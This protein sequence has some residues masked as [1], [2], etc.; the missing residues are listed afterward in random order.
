MCEDLQRGARVKELCPKTCGVCGTTAAPKTAAPTA[1]A[2]DL[3]TAIVTQ[4]PSWSKALNVT[5]ES[6]G[7][8][9]SYHV[10]FSNCEETN[11][12]YHCICGECSDSV[13]EFIATT[14][15]Q[16]WCDDQCTSRCK[17]SPTTRGGSGKGEQED[18]RLVGRAIS[19]SGVVI[20]PTSVPLDKVTKVPGTLTCVDDDA[21]MKE[22][23][24]GKAADCTGAAD[25]CED[26]QRGARVK[27]L[28]P[29]TCG[30]CTIAPSAPLLSCA[31]GSSAVAGSCQPCPPG[32]FTMIPGASCSRCAPGTF[33]SSEGQASCQLCP[34]GSFSSTFGATSC[35]KCQKGFT[36]TRGQLSCVP[37]PVG[38]S[39]DGSSLP[40]N[41]DET[42]P[43]ARITGEQMLL[44]FLPSL[45]DEDDEVTA[46]PTKITGEQMLL[47]FLP[48]LATD[49]PKNSPAEKPVDEP[50][51]MCCM[52]MT[53]ECLACKKGVSVE[54][55]C[56]SSANKEYCGKPSACM[57]DEDC[58]AGKECY[59]GGSDHAACVTKGNIGIARPTHAPVPMVFL[60]LW[61]PCSLSQFNAVKEPLKG[62]L[63]ARA[64]ISPSRLHFG[65]PKSA[66]ATLPAEENSTSGLEQLQVSTGIEVPVEIEDGPGESA[67]QAADLLK[68]ANLT[69]LVKLVG[70]GAFF[71]SL[72]SRKNSLIAQPPKSLNAASSPASQ[73]SGSLS[74][75]WVWP[76]VLFGSTLV[77]VLGYLAL[78]HKR[79]QSASKAR[80]AS[81]LL[82]EE[83]QDRRLST[84]GSVSSPPGPRQIIDPH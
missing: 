52:A 68:K 11:F 69:E 59:M 46:A 83:V 51:R 65:D 24:G 3:P 72:P 22:F 21:G 48:T 53:K 43:P 64:G 77:V 36:A 33:G 19:S 62:K 27:E 25:M 67:Q 78:K 55:F 38:G 42:Q 13:L 39:A 17:R 2:T 74:K 18:R 54:D 8:P 5:T 70:A 40:S 76:V 31:P 29:K 37:C 15:T 20:H 7:P 58:D 79:S 34:E 49:T 6:C 71:E 9:S 81:S 30:A 16:Q 61:M 14:A 41:G 56:K 10:A 26:L 28:C 60:P 80:R 12:D 45:L 82:F 47:T 44:T 84:R 1:S 4:T 50:T 75:V 32:S 66:T 23:S 73:A 63:A 57:T 35:Q